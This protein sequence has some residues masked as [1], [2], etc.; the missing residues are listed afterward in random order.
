MSPSAQEIQA[1]I[2]RVVLTVEQAADYFGVGRDTI[3]SMTHLKE[4]EDAEL[5]HFHIGAGKGGIRFYRALLDLWAISNTLGG[6]SNDV[7]AL[8]R[9]CIQN[10]GR[11]TVVEAAKEN[12]HG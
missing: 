10:I 1:S 9:A 6:S 2:Q 8:K 7:V 5:P 3:Y 11:G 4:G 12:A